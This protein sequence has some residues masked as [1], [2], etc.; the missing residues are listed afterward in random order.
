MSNTVNESVILERKRIPGG[1]GGYIIPGGKPGNAGGGAPSHAF[2]HEA[3]AEA[4]KRG[5]NG[6]TAT[7]FLGRLAR[8]EPGKPGQDDPTYQVSIAAN[9]ALSKYL[10]TIT[11]AYGADVTAEAI[12]RALPQVLSRYVG[13]AE[14]CAAFIRELAEASKVETTL[15]F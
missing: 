9:L 6:H 13:D 3:L 4:K 5:E 15:P 7:E 14:D 12:L 1:R 2:I 8:G 11:V 10:P